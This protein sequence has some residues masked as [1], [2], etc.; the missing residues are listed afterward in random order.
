MIVKLLLAT[1]AVDPDSKSY[2]GQT[3]LSWAAGNGHEEVVK[4]LQPNHVLSS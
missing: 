1:D 3:P 2:N 4:L